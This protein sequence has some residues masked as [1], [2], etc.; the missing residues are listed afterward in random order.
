MQEMSGWE[1]LAIAVVKSAADDY[2]KAVKRAR[3][4]GGNPVGGRAIERFF[5]SEY[6]DLL[7]FGHGEEIW[8][9]LKKEGEENAGK[10]EGKRHNKQGAKKSR[11]RV[12]GRGTQQTGGRQRAAHD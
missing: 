10:N 2:R 11:A 6:G 9:Q 12:G 4:T 5:K 3:K 8:R 7:T 1:L